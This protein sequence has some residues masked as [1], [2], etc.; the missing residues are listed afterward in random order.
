VTA[1]DIV[2]MS[3]AGEPLAGTEVPGERYLHSA[4]Y[5]R[6][7]DVTSVLHYHSTLTAAFG[8]LGQELVPRTPLAPILAPAVA[9]HNYGGQIDTPDKG[10]ALCES[11]SDRPAVLLPGHGA[12]VVGAGV[13]EV[14][15]RAVALEDCCRVELAAAQVGAPNAATVPMSTAGSREVA[16][17]LWRDL[18][19]GMSAHGD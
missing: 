16:F 12:V 7:P 4:I 15:A 3:E 11:L 5:A 13:E 9:A 2:S 1:A 6:R 14:S 19:R 8:L 18:V 17:V 10:A